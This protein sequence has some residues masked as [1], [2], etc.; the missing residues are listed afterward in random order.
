[1]GAT[2]ARPRLALRGYQLDAVESIVEADREGIGR[3]LAVLPTGA[4]KTVVAVEVHR[5]LGGS[6]LFLGH[7]DEL[8]GQA[9]A[10][11]RE[12]DPGADIGVVKAE[13]NET[14]ARVVIASVQT[15]A[16]ERRL[17]ELAGPFRL[18]VVDE[19]HHATAPSYRAVLDRFG[20]PGTLV[21]GITATPGRADGIGL[22]S[23]FD[24]ISYEIGILD[25]IEQGYLSDVRGLRVDVAMDL[26]RVAIRGGDFANGQL[27]SA[28][29]EANGPAA[30][31]DAVA[32]HAADRAA[33]LVFAP[34]VA[35]AHQTA[36]A[37]RRLGIEAEA[38]DG[39]VPLG[40]RRAVI[41][42]FRSGDLRV[43]TNCG[44]ATEG[45]DVPRVDCV[46]VAR[47]TRSAALYQ[48]MVGRGT[49]L[50]PG[51]SDCLVLD[52][53]GATT[54][55]RLQSVAD[56]VGLDPDD[57]APGETVARAVE[58]KRRLDEERREAERL[59]AV[60][61]ARARRTLVVQ[62]VD[63]FGRDR[64][65]ILADPNASWRRAPAT[66]KQLRFL[67]RLGIAP[68]PG[69]TKGDASS[70]IDRALAVSRRAS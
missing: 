42:R 10:K 50:A 12:A 48:Q 38:V 25:L 2:N 54:R 20:G 33:V 60:E 32:L 40:D 53:V 65:A 3:V 30:T 18:I 45:F 67:I 31:A 49:R 34:S 52:M 11:F 5:R 41:G 46:V 1:M 62:A 56:L 27:G 8:I 26:D 21:L 43:M 4:G 7:R 63:P 36:A 55:H 15:L 68:P 22:G 58:R 47:P 39:G 70:L 44:I 69:L 17:G 61:A 23:V 9:A 51:K 29:L 13:R 24:R 66:D 28:F 6:A 64:P 37:M 35:A 59:A 14:T 19:A 16:S 57:V